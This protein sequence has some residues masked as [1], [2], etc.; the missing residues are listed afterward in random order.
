MSDLR[1]IR[2]L[3]KTNYQSGNSHAHRAGIDR[4]PHRRRRHAIMPSQRRQNR[5]SREE[6]NDG[7]KR[8]KTDDD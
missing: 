2:G 6:V 1:S 8:H 3:K 7:Q 5:L 4:E